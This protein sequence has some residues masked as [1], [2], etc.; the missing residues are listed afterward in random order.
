M[1]H[2]FAAGN[3]DMRNEVYLRAGEGLARFLRLRKRQYFVSLDEAGSPG[4][5]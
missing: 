1:V 5:E 4:C 3:I 2:A